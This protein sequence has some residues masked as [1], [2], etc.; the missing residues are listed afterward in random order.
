[1]DA[2]AARQFTLK[3]D[4]ER[5]AQC[6]QVRA[7]MAASQDAKWIECKT[8]EQRRV[9]LQVLALNV[10]LSIALAAAG[11]A[12]DSSALIA[13]ALDNASDSAVYVIS[14][15]ALGRSP[16]WKSAAARLSGVLLLAFAA[17]ILGDAVRRFLAGSEPL[18]GIMAAFAVVAAGVNL[19]CLRLLQRL[20]SG[21]VNLRAAT[22]F[23]FN[24]FVSNSGILIAGGLVAWTGRSW[25]DLVIGAAIAAVAL[26]G[27]LEILGEAR[28][29]REEN[30]D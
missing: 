26:K 12:A 19:L 8:Q 29:A 13:N 23:S 22:T 6:G 18:G 24:D 25:P 9:L 1:M 20:H 16:R 10:L 17:G 2:A 15:F 14:Y 11:L 3:E 7:E 21:D 5:A 28:H 30:K 4:R 27:G